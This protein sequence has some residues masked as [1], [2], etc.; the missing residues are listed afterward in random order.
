MVLLGLE[1]VVLV[2]GFLHL[3]PSWPTLSTSLLPHEL[4]L[5]VLLQLPLL[6]HLPIDREVESHGI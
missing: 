5:E 1:V 4:R 3:L 2:L 6:H